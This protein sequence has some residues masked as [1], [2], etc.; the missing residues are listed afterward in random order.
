MQR[1]IGGVRRSGRCGQWRREPAGG[2]DGVRQAAWRIAVTAT[3][4]LLAAGFTACGADAEGR[5]DGA[6]GAAL[7]A[8]PSADVDATP[9]PEVPGRLYS[10]NGTGWEPWLSSPPGPVGALELTG[11]GT[12]VG[13]GATLWGWEDATW[14]LR[15]AEAPGRIESYLR[16]GAGEFVAVDDRLYRWNDVAWEAYLDPA[17]APIAEFQYNGIGQFIAAGDQVYS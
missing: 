17:P 1:P 8:G 6:D 5:A 4:A 13:V 12:A 10:W 2:C 3:G 7:D 16:S 11:L 15:H 14:T 9:V